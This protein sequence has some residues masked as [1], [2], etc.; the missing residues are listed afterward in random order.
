MLHFAKIV[1]L[2]LEVAFS[3]GFSRKPIK[4]EGGI[5]KSGK[6]LIVVCIILIAG[7]GITAGAL[8][9]MNKV[10][11]VPVTKT[12]QLV[13]QLTQQIM[14]QLVILSTKHL[15]TV[16]YISNIHP[17]GMFYLTQLILWP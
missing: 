8:I 11:T 3:D 4:K 2:I 12:V 5:N 6:I 13:K 15:V 16:K 17:A 14:R 1:A 10:S 7:L 9:E